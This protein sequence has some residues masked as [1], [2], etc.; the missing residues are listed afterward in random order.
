MK[1]IQIIFW[2]RCWFVICQS[3]ERLLKVKTESILNGNWRYAEIIRYK[4]SALEEQSRTKIEREKFKIKIVSR[5]FPIFFCETLL[6]ERFRNWIFIWRSIRRF[7][8]FIFVHNEIDYISIYE[9]VNYKNWTPAANRMK[10]NECFEPLEPIDCCSPSFSLLLFV[11]T[12]R[13][14]TNVKIIV[15]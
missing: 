10:Q 1:K 11:Y 7:C 8:S 9:I 12:E 5:R 14:K 13:T 6:T 15:E 3:K 4:R 2:F